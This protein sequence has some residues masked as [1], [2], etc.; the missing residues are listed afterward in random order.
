MSHPVTS[1]IG[2]GIQK[3]V[4][5]HGILDYT[6]HVITSDPTEFGENRNLQN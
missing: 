2:Q 5:Y 1:D 6:D 4:F 3:W